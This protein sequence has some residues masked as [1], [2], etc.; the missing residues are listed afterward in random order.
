MTRVP[1]EPT[2]LDPDDL[3]EEVDEVAEPKKAK[4]DSKSKARARPQVSRMP[5]PQLKITAPPPAHPKAAQGKSTFPD[6]DAMVLEPRRRADATGQSNDRIGLARA[7]IE[8]ALILEVLKGDIQGALAEYRAAHAIAPSALAP[9]AAARRLTPV[10][11][12]PPALSIL[13]AELRATT[14][15]STRAVRL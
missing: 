12:V 10:R 11:P 2:E 9:I 6:V 1:H 7:R 15:G 8:L 13:E 5:A 4:R 14:D 3:V